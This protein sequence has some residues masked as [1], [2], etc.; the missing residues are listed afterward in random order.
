MLPWLQQHW[1]ALLSFVISVLAFTLSYKKFK[2]DTRPALVL[3]R[4]SEGTE[5]ENVGQVVA[6][7]VTLTLV[8]KVKRPS[9]RL[10]VVDTLRPGDKSTVRAFDWPESLTTELA[11]NT[12]ESM[13]EFVLG[14]AGKKVRPDGTKV[15]AYLLSRA[16]KRV[17]I[18]RFRAADGSKTFVRLFQSGREKLGEFT[19]L[20]PSHKVLRNRVWAAALQKY[21]G[22]NAELAPPLPPLK[23]P[24]H[25]KG[26]VLEAGLPDRFGE[27]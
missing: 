9:G 2:Y 22:G 4:G 6:V 1:M 5:V 12:L 8:E 23:F 14:M 17:V 16:G 3:R 26:D 7:G 25:E 19:V 18:L 21:Y 27:N 15:A 13:D 10:G 20:T 24:R 11:R